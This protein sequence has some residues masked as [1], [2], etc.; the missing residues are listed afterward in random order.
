MP[1][2]Q[3]VTVVVNQ[4]PKIGLAPFSGDVLTPVS[5][6]VNVALDVIGKVVTADDYCPRENSFE[7]RP[8]CARKLVGPARTQPVDRAILPPA[9]CESPSMFLRALP[10]PARIPPWD[11][12]RCDAS[13]PR[14]KQGS[15]SWIAEAVWT[16]SEH[17]AYRATVAPARTHRAGRGSHRRVRMRVWST[18]QVCGYMASSEVAASR[19]RMS[20]PAGLA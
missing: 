10:E 20:G 5:R 7:S 9:P 6:H 16:Y 3:G 11:N 8:V 17:R 19:P 2:L 4:T 12:G 15:A 1:A 13:G 18:A 14:P